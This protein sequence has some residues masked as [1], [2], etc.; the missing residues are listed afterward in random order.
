MSPSSVRSVRPPEGRSR[1]VPVFT[2]IFEMA[3]LV[4]TLLNVISLRFRS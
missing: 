3:W 2:S 4:G 1:R